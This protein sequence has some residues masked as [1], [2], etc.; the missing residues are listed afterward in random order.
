MSWRT[1]TCR[2]S[3]SSFARASATFCPST[4]GIFTALDTSSVIAWPEST[5]VPMAGSVPI[6]LPDSI[7]RS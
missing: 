1:C 7:A 6:T 3:P 2:P 4:P 5:V